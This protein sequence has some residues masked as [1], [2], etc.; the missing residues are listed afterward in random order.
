[1]NSQPLST[2][3]SPPISPREGTCRCGEVRMKVTCEPVTT[4]ACHCRGCQR[5]TASAFSL[6]ALIPIDG[7][8]IVTGA[9][10]RG[11]A[12]TDGINHYHCPRCMSWLFTKIDM[13]PQFVNLRAT[14]FDEPDWSRP[15]V[16]TMT[17][18]KL[19]WV[20]TPAQHSFEQF[21]SP[22]EVQ[23]LLQLG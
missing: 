21:P 10:V 19:D 22:E 7:L 4:F 2:D 17:C 3:K 15:R 9:P 13:L 23:S 18:E 8:E 6:S 20:T 12:H 1:M 5:M 11:G 16:E 14:M